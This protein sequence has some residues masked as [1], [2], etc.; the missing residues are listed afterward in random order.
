MGLALFSFEIPDRT[1]AD[2][3]AARKLVLR[4][5]QKPSGGTTLSRS[6][7]HAAMLERIASK[8]NVMTNYCLYK[9]I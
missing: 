2:A 7:C 1:N 4:P 3:D 9:E 6:D 8:G 5:V